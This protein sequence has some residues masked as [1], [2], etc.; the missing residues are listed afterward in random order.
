MYERLSKIYY[1]DSSG[2]QAEYEKRINS[3]GTVKL[4]F[5][6]KPF[7][8]SDEFECFYVNHMELDILH[9]KI[10]KQSNEIQFIAD[11]LPPIAIRQY[12]QAK[13]VD[14]LMSTNEIEGVQSTRAEMT[15]AMAVREK[16]ATK[17]QKKVRHLS[18]VN[19]YFKLLADKNGK[20]TSLEQIKEI[21]DSLVKDE[22]KEEDQLDG[23]I[24]RSGPVDVVTSTQKVIHKG[25]YPEM[26]IQSS[27]KDLI[28]YLNEYN[29]P[30]LYKI[31]IAHYYFGYIH[32]FYDGNG[33]TSR[34][35]ASMYLK[36]ELDQLTAL[37]LS[38]STNKLK[39]YYYDIFNESNNPLNK[40]ELTFF[41]H[42]FFSIVYQAQEDILEDLAERVEKIGQLH[43]LI[44][45]LEELDTLCKDILFIIGQD[46]IFGLEGEGIEKSILIKG[47]DVTKYKVDKSLKQLREQEL[48]INTKNNPVKVTLSSG[49]S[50][51][52]N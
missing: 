42:T 27:L 6:I 48:V 29:A 8:G 25:I 10:I 13:L 32:P 45:E 35:I 36:E 1:K 30:M 7:K 33:R 38:Y 5:R 51:Q 28:N 20:I 44:N 9:E 18:L 31:A 2:Y 17:T 43:Q 15:D 12:I 34:Y 19:S 11:K 14:E 21:Y 52:L 39:Q 41:C 26:L 24:F 23:E 4:P 40:G 16:K 22:I 50:D 47:L 3:Y 37:T 46:Y 49:L